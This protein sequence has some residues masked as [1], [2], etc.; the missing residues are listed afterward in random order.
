M[1]PEVLNQ[2]IQEVVAANQNTMALIALTQ[3]QLQQQE[4][5]LET[6][7]RQAD[8]QAGALEVLRDLQAQLAQETSPQDAPKSK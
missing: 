6:L 2:K 8:M 5:Q 7:Q 3:D 1:N 4:A